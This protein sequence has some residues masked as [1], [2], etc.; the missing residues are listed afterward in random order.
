METTATQRFVN[1]GKART[2]MPNPEG[3]DI[4]VHPFEECLNP[5]TRR[6]DAVYVV[7]GEFWERYAGGHGAALATF[8]RPASYGVAA[9]P[10]DLAALRADGSMVDSAGNA[11]D[12]D[13]GAIA[14]QAGAT[15][16]RIAGDVITPEGKI[17]RTNPLTGVEELVEDTEANR[18]MQHSRTLDEDRVELINVKHQEIQGGIMAWMERMGIE[19]AEQL[20]DMSDDTL[21]TIPGVEL[22]MVK[23]LRENLTHHFQGLAER[24]P[25]EN[26]PVG[27]VAATA[28]VSAVLPADDEAGDVA[29]DEFAP[30]EQG[31]GDAVSRQTDLPAGRA[32]LHPQP[33]D[34][35][36]PAEGREQPAHLR[37]PATD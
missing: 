24:V 19:S 5:R 8:P 28:S 2:T 4:T 27:A 33:T 21:A 35:Q 26:T 16:K 25:A 37:N 11:V 14:V 20:A 17:R 30:D 29:A 32:H 34:D 1:L 18:N 6:P 10:E 3:Q 12:T 23:Q 31:D 9:F 22:V 36:L 15:K 7:E 13:A